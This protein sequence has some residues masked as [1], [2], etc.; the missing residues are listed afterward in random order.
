MLIE[1]SLS[2]LFESYGRFQRIGIRLQGMEG[3][4]NVLKSGDERTTILRCGLIQSRFSG[5][6][7]VQQYP[8]V[9][10]GLCNV[11]D[12]IPENGSG[13]EQ[14]TEG[15]CGAAPAGAKGELGQPGCDSYAQLGAGGMQLLLGG[16]DIRALFDK[17]GREAD[18]QFL[19]KAESGELEFFLGFLAGEVAGEGREQIA[20]LRKLFVERG[21]GLPHLGEYRFLCRQLADPAT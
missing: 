4:R 13:A 9:K 6:L 14:L 15:L 5:L 17:L 1:A 21:Q 12:Q 20:G 11:T 3:I 7:P 16:A 8:T 19:R 10:Y 2:G 18:R